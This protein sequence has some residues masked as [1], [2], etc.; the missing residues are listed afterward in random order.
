[1]I[2]LQYILTLEAGT[3]WLSDDRNEIESSEH[4][5][6]ASIGDS[7]QRVTGASAEGRQHDRDRGT[8]LLL[9]QREMQTFIDLWR[10][11]WGLVI[12]T[13]QGNNSKRC[14][15]LQKTWATRKSRSTCIL[16]AGTVS[17]CKHPSPVAWSGPYNRAER[18]GMYMDGKE[19]N[20]YHFQWKIS[21]SMCR[22]EWN[23][24]QK[25]R[26]K[27]EGSKE[28]RHT[29]K[30][31]MLFQASIRQQ[32]PQVQGHCFQQ[33]WTSSHLKVPRQPYYHNSLARVVAHNENQWEN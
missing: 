14:F 13:G 21:V 24:T 3:F 12:S 11:G 7:A 23:L 8:R 20:T 15:F 17:S 5:G 29:M 16:A 25:L 22:T 28:G 26:S 32:L 9:K 19:E 31:E 6:R 10:R 27:G 2:L 30:R 4:T 33:K 18:L 1:M